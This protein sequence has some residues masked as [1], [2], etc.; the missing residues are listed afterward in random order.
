LKQRGALI[1]GRKMKIAAFQFQG[2]KDVRKNLL[3][4]ER[5]LEKA[6]KE[7]VRFLLTQECAICGYPP[8]ETDKVSSIDFEMVAKAI[9]RIK[10]LAAKNNM[11]IGLGTIIPDNGKYF[12]SIA[13]VSPH[14]ENLVSYS[15][16]ALWG[17]DA[18]N[19]TQGGG[20]GIYTIDKLKIGIRICYE[21]RFPEYFRELFK[22]NV[23]IAFVSFC[24]ISSKPDSERYEIIK[25]HLV[26]RA[27]ENAMWVIFV[28]SISKHQTAPTCLIDPDGNVL[29]VAP[30]DREYLLKFN[31]VNPESNFGR[32]GRIKHSKELTDG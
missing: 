32:E 7:N 9:D 16:R 30:K 23:Q 14:Q 1:K 25:S 8:V 27:V 20:S 4:I 13:L 5:G 21:V 19:F 29:E 3:A 10:E 22:E 24:D 28:N 15:K 6:S 11:Y 17:W 12:N 26:T 2:S 18:E 31:L